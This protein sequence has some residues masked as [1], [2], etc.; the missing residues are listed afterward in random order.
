MT[1]QYGSL[2]VIREKGGFTVAKAKAFPTTLLVKRENEGTDEE[3]LQTG[4]AP[5]EFAEV[6]ETVVVAEYRLVRTDKLYTVVERHSQG[7]TAKG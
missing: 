6:G 3:Y 5:E 2:P 4:E 1:L 7:K